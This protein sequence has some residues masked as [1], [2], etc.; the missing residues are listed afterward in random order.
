MKSKRHASMKDVES[1]IHGQ[2]VSNDREVVKVGLSNVVFWGF[3]SQGIQEYRVRKFRKDVKD[4]HLD[5]FM[6]VV[7]EEDH[8]GLGT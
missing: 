7:N 6:E 1:L 2:L 3:A 5:G 8:I 4:Y